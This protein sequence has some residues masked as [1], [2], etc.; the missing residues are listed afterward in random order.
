MRNELVLFGI[1]WFGENTN[2]MRSESQPC[3]YSPYSTTP[4]PITRLSFLTLTIT[5]TLPITSL[6][7]M[8]SAIMIAN[9]TKERKSN[10]NRYVKKDIVHGCKVSE[11]IFPGGLVG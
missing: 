4:Y 11:I 9:G 6:L 8:K 1:V 7:G 10:R 2:P 3:S 5:V